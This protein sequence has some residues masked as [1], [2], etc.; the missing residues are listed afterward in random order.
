MSVVYRRKSIEDGFDLPDTVMYDIPRKRNVADGRSEQHEAGIRGGRNAAVKWVVGRSSGA[1]PDQRL[2]RIELQTKIVA[3]GL[4]QVEGLL[5]FE[6][7]T[8]N[9]DVIEER[10]VQA[11]MREIGFDAGG[12]GEG[13][14]QKIRRLE[15]L[16]VERQRS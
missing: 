16:L 1:T 13:R 10:D 2:L 11:K 5:Q 4:Q 12:W 15:G 6:A 7:A 9:G 14:G 8:N 3:T